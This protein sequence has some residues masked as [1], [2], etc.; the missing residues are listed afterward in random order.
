M[1]IVDWTVENVPDY[2]LPYLFNGDLD[3]LDEEDVKNVLDYEKALIDWR[4]EQEGYSWDIELMEEEPH[5][6]NSPAFGLPCM[7]FE[8]KL[9]ILG[10]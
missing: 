3:G 7:A 4:D 8:C 5:F 9:M 2:A 1:R 10:E 6:T